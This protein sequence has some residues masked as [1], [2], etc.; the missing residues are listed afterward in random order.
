MRF[1][2]KEG[3]KGQWGEKNV[4]GFEKLNLDS[5]YNDGTQIR[6]FNIESHFAGIVSPAASFSLL[7]SRYISVWSDEEPEKHLTYLKE[8]VKKKKKLSP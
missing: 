2:F 4:M 7:G 8:R 1:A 3:M 6:Y 5:L